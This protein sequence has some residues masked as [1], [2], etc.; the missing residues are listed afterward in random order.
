M[1][2]TIL[3][4]SVAVLLTSTLCVIVHAQTAAHWPQWR[5]PFFNGMAR[6]DAPSVWSDTT[7]IKWKTEIPGRGFSTP[8]IWGDRI[9]LTTAIPTGKAAETPQP[10]PAP[11][12][13]RRAGGGGG[14]L[15]EH[16]FEVLALDRKTGKI[17][18]Q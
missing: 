14:P 3:I 9:F 15:V 2:K 8:V 16:R 11:A 18:W 7:N 12:E 4:A 6:G 1:K 13:G 5:G 10:Q 17:L